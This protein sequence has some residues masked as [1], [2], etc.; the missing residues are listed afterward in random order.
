MVKGAW[1]GRRDEVGNPL[2]GRPFLHLAPELDVFLRLAV[3]VVTQ[4]VAG[5]GDPDRLV[6]K[7]QY[8][9][10]DQ[11]DAGVG[12]GQHIEVRIGAI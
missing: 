7:S 10:V 12:V 8:I 2:N 3:P 6:T 4:I 9:V 5:F 1:S 11:L